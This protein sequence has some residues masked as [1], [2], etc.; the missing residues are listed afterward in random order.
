LSFNSGASVNLQPESRVSVV[1]IDCADAARKCVIA[2]NA[3]K[4]EVHSE[5]T[6][7]PAG[8]PAVEFSVDTPFLSAAVRGTAFYV[9]VDQS[10]NKIGVTRGMVAAESNGTAND[11]PKGKGMLAVPEEA[12]VVV[13]LLTPPELS[14]QDDENVVFSMEDVVSWN[15]LE[16]AVK[17]RVAIAN[18]PS[19]VNPLLVQ[20]VTD[21]FVVPA[22]DSV[23]EYFT[24][25]VGIDDQGFIGLP[26]N[27]SFQY[28]LIEDA[29]PPELVI[30][31]V[32]SVAEISTP[33]YDGPVEIQMSNSID[34]AVVERHMLDS[35]SEGVELE[36]SPARDWVFRAR[37]S[38]SETS[39]S[40]YG[41]EYL[42]KAVE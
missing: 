31:R 14:A 39:V 30:Q 27:T 38:I 37:K 35:M 33:G 22:V 4:G 3:D 6:P 19:M 15:E 24:S 9:D 8:Q 29:D 21:N 32:G 28:V 25:I 7:G 20:E 18:D 12:P 41:N 42:L 16:G 34:G 5:I 26:L 17:Y 11:L 13:D 40:R 2:L 23:G 36:L 1:D 10:A